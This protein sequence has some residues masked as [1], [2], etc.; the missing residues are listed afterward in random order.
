VANYSS[1]DAIDTLRL[2][3]KLPAAS[4]SGGGVDIK[5]AD[6][7]NSRIWIAYPWRWTLG[8]LTAIVL[9]DGQ[10]DYVIGNNDHYRPVNLWV[11][12]TDLTPDEYQSFRAIVEHLPPELAIKV[13]WQGF[14]TISWE[15][16][17]NKFRLEAAASVPAGITMSINGDYQ[18][19]PTKI[20]ALSTALLQDDVYFETY[21]DWLLYY[22]YK[23]T[24][25]SRM[26]GVT[27]TGDGRKQ[28]NGQL[29]KAFESLNEM[30]AA[31]DKGDGVPLIFPDEPLVGSARGGG[32]SIFG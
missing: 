9:V 12:R 8:S 24:D 29:A 21:C 10:Q 23:F 17:I 7:A 3:V 27:I 28:Y 26:G 6:M 11:T 13:G 14:G 15:K 18:K 22:L 16:S 4:L 2:H 20:T 19:V 32:M 1:Q 5:A 30:M 31:E 25:D